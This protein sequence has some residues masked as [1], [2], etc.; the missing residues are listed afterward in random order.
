M[1]PI[2]VSELLD[3]TADAVVAALDGLDD[4]GLAGTE[5]AS[6]YRSD[7]VA[8]AA[9]LA[10]LSEAGVDVVSEESALTHTG[11]GHLVV[12]IDPL[13]GSTNASRRLPASAVSMCALDRHGPQASLV[14]E[15]PTDTR[16][17]AV[18]DHGA[19]RDGEPFGCPDPEPL[20]RA[21]ITLNGHAPVEL[22]AWQ[23]RAFGAAAVELCHVASGGLDGYVSCDRDGHGPWD[24]LGALLICTEAGAAMA[25]AFGRDLVV[26]DHEA[27]RTVMAAGSTELLDELI[28]ARRGWT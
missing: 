14:V 15:L 1:T 21:V 23:Y 6:Q 17:S 13:D 10:V 27:R 18:R 4:W 5:K 9:A 16:W 25:D 26:V 8:D 19:K 28:A 24:Y 3:R 2:E 7:L 11:A 12:V 22:G 20:E